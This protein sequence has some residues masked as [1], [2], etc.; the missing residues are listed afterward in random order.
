MLNF[1]LPGTMHVDMGITHRQNSAAS[2]Y[3]NDKDG[4]IR[5]LSHKSK[6]KV[7]EK[8]LIASVQEH[9]FFHHRHSCS[10]TYG[11][12]S[13]IVSSIG[14]TLRQDVAKLC[15]KP[16]AKDTLIDFSKYKLIDL[17]DPY[18]YMVFRCRSIDLL[19]TSIENLDYK[20]AESIISTEE[21]IKSYFKIYL[22]KS[23][24]TDEEKE[25]LSRSL[26]CVEIIEAI[27]T[28]KQYNW[29]SLHWYAGRSPY[30]QELEKEW[31][32]WLGQNNP[33]YLNAAN[34][35]YSRCNVALKNSLFGII[36]NLSL[37]PPIFSQEIK[38]WSEFS[39]SLRLEAILDACKKLPKK[40]LERD[41]LELIT[42]DEYTY[43]IDKIEGQLG[44]H[45][46]KDIISDTLIDI[47]KTLNHLEKYHKPSSKG[48]K[49]YFEKLIHTRLIYAHTVQFQNGFLDNI[50]YP[51]YMLFPWYHPM[52]T[53]VGNLIRPIVTQY[54]DKLFINIMRMEDEPNK[55]FVYDPFGIFIL[56]QD[57]TEN[58]WLLETFNQNIEQSPKTYA[59]QFYRRIPDA[60][61][62]HFNYSKKVKKEVKV[63]LKNWKTFEQFMSKRLNKDYFTY[64]VFHE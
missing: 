2:Y 51:G 34:Y 49:E 57:M 7:F 28:W 50:I 4:K 32:S 41:Y 35:I 25:K 11:Y 12:L 62:T 33:M 30:A 45:R 9:E 58:I 24:P 37:N 13:F 56:L 6:D 60:M 39:P 55:S 14:L 47:N 21:L 29:L 52:S 40:Y 8:S 15:P 59:R 42:Q 3:L 48:S 61:K 46:S 20:V 43:I 54:V 19:L 1:Y 36:L 53:F 64:F 10:I 31:I 23:A 63:L 27:A 17:K 18:L 5:D 26:S 38:S 22:P 16:K 44:W